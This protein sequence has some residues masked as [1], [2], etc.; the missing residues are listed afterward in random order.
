M[1]FTDYAVV[2]AISYLLGSI[3]FGYLLVRTL[4]GKD[5]RQTGSGNIGATNVARLGAPGLALATLVLDAGKGFVAVM[6][7]IR[8]FAPDLPSAEIGHDT[9]LPGVVAA[10]FVVS[11]HIFPLWLR[12][13]GGK[14]VA[15]AVGAFLGL[16]PKG[17]LGVLIIFGFLAAAFRYISLGSIVAIALFPLFAYL[18][19]GYRHSPRVLAT[20]YLT[21]AIIIVRHRANIRRLLAGS[22]PR[23]EIKRHSNS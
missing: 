19:D 16:A 10:F 13:R 6:L 21:S 18:F 9:A 17:L 20:M 11:G 7:V 15:T 5:I 3:P 22:E 8:H 12:F 2:A 4:R 14:G 1:T 23:F